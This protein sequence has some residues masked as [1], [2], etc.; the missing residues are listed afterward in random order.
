MRRDW[1]SWSGS[2][3]KRDGF[4]VL[5]RPQH[6]QRVMEEIEWD[7]SNDTGCEGKKQ[8]PQVGMREVQAEYGEEL[9]P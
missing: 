9:S 2:A 5:N 8:W 6:H 7:F 3:G 1:G 4:G